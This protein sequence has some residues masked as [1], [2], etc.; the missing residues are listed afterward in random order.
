MSENNF[1]IERKYLVDKI[2]FSLESYEKVA[3][4]QSYIS[5][6]PTIRIRK[7]NDDYILTI[8]GSGDIKKVELEMPLTEKEYNNLLDK[9]EG[10]TIKKSR[11][12]IPLQNGLI[13]ELDEYYGFLDGLFTVE[14]EFS[15]VEEY[16]K[17]IPEKWFGADVSLD[18]RYKNAYLSKGDT[19]HIFG[20]NNGN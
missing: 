10:K 12:I 3:V 6:K 20:G 19:S 4:E 16:E 11:Y 5:T 13:A 17:F 14:V 7:W 2:P 1:E 18:K 9:V 15:S 8:K